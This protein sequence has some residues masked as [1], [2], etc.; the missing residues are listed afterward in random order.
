M[1]DH[2]SQIKCLKLRP[3]TPKYS[4]CWINIG[5]RIDVFENA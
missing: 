3:I 2:T 1:H 4:K 5:I